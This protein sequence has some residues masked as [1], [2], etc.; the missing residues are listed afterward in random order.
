MR[1]TDDIHFITP[2]GV[3]FGNSFQK[4]VWICKRRGEGRRRY[5]EKDLSDGKVSM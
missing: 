2:G 4:G 5:G 1:P 3:Y